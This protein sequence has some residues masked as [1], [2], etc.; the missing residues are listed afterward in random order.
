MKIGKIISFIFIFAIFLCG[1]G[2]SIFGLFDVSKDFD[3]YYR[4]KNIAVTV[5]AK[6]TYVKEID[7][8]DDDSDDTDYDAYITYTYNREKY[9]DVL[10][11]RYEKKPDISKT[12]YVEIDPENPTH[13]RPLNNGIGYAV[14][15]IIVSTIFIAIPSS[16]LIILLPPIIA[17]NNKKNIY[18]SRKLSNQAVTED[19]LFES[20]LKQKIPKIILIFLLVIYFLSMIISYF[21]SRSYTAPTLFI[22]YSLI[23]TSI[24]LIV[25]KL[26]IKK[27]EDVSVIIIK[28][29]FIDTS[30]YSDN[31]GHDTYYWKFEKQNSWQMDENQF[32]SFSG[33]SAKDVE[34]GTKVY[35]AL[36]NGRIVRV[37]YGEDFTV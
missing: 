21:L 28:D 30:K 37:F 33:L 13:L 19:L 2:F 32:I 34:K 25:F 14:L 7:N 11:K 29:K 20:R 5:E 16:A 9:Q 15:C 8:S 24:Y 18:T 22:I 4:I 36:N 1:L 6:I 27:S 10:Y 31:D 35:L 3:E 23:L 17:K 26:L 12:L